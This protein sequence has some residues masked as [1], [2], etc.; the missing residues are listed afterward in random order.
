MRTSNNLKKFSIRQWRLWIQPSLAG[1]MDCAR[2]EMRVSTEA[3]CHTEGPDEKKKAGCI[4]EEHG[5]TH[6]SLICTL[7]HQA[8]ELLRRAVVA[9]LLVQL[10]HGGQQLIDDGFQL[11]T[12]Y[13]LTSHRRYSTPP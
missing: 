9:V 6:R 7:L 10:L 2:Y 13:G 5:S 11:C 4:Q 12:A 1:W 3:S 8:E